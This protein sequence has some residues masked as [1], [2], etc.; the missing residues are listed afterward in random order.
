[1]AGT[2][3]R[4]EKSYLEAMTRIDQVALS[5][6]NPDQ[7][8]DGM[9]EAVFRIFRCDRAWLIHPCDPEAASFE[10]NAETTQPD[11]PG[12][13]ALGTTIPMTADMA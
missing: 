2:Q 13:N 8:V 7:M 12:A 3:R 1:M 10:V 4:H 6:N 5:S 11:Y 9:V